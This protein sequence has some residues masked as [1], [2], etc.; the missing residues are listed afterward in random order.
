MAGSGQLF[1]Q[2]LAPPYR[3]CRMYTNGA[4]GSAAM[5]GSQS[6][7]VRSMGSSPAHPAAG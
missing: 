2:A 5:A 1:E 6:S 7:A 3:L 4:L